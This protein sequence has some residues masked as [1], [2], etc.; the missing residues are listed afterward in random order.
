MARHGARVQLAQSDMRLGLNMA[1]MAKVS[2]LR[3]AIEDTTYLM[4]K[5]IAEIPEENM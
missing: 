4:K 5:P 3:A 2:F 1:N